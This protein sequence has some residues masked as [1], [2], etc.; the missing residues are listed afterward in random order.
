MREI[1]WYKEGVSAER[2]EYPALLRYGFGAVPSLVGSAAQGTH[3][4][5]NDLQEV[6]REEIED[7]I[8]RRVDSRF[9]AGDAE[10]FQLLRCYRQIPE[11]IHEA[12]P[13]HSNPGKRI[14]RDIASFAI[15]LQDHQDCF[16]ALASSLVSIR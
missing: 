13:D 3:G 9:V 4:P 10:I 2:V 5:C 7:Q 11:E 6:T 8:I 15:F 14:S 1:E 16:Q 12:I